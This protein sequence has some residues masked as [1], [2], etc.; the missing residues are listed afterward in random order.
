MKPRKQQKVTP[1]EEEEYY[2]EAQDWN[3]E[4]Y[5]SAKKRA[6]IW[7]WSFFMAIGV[8]LLEGLALAGLAPLKTAVPYVIKV[9]NS[10]GIVEILEPLSERTV[11]Q[12]EALL[13]Y[14]IVK[15]LTAREQYD[16]QSFE[17]DSYT[18]SKMSSPKV[19]TKYSQ[20][21]APSVETSPYNLYADKATVEIN[22]RDITFLDKDTAVVHVKR[23][24]NMYQEKRESYWIITLSFKFQL[25]PESE[26]D[27][28]INPLGFQVTNYRKDQEI[29]EG[30]RR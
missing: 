9:D 19:F 29:V 16:I 26:S 22:V 5:Q 4:K 7:M 10:S 25:T 18:V 28:F 1:E 21:Y 15:Y 30:N 17:H 2:K 3:E 14:W 13:K 8:A 6:A 27:R 11:P 20:V 23:T 24:L 12:D